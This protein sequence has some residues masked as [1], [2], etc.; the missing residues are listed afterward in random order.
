MRVG[1]DPSAKKRKRRRAGRKRAVGQGT[2]R[3]RRKDNDPLQSFDDGLGAG[4]EA[5]AT[6]HDHGAA[7]AEEEDDDDYGD[8]GEDASAIPMEDR[9]YQTGEELGKSTAGRVEWQKRHKKG[10]FSGKPKLKPKE[11][12]FRRF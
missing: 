7:H 9:I 3:Q 4:A 2:D 12:K 11:Y 10:K 8:D 5:E 6:I 1:K